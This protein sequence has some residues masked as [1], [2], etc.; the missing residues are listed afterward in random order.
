MRP[1]FKTFLILAFLLRGVMPLQAQGIDIQ[2]IHPLNWYVGMKNPNVQ[3][4]IYGKNIAESKLTLRPYAGVTLKS[5]HK[6]EN[7]NYL[8]VD[9]VIAKNAKAGNLQ[10][11]FNKKGEKTV[12]NYE[13]K[14]RSAKPQGLSP[15]DL[16]YLIMPDRFANGDPANDKF[17]TMA[18]TNCDRKAHSLRHGGDIQ[19]I[20]NHLDYINDLGATAIWLTPVIENDQPIYTYNNQPYSCYHGYAFTDHYQVDARFGD[21]ALYAKFVE[22]AHKKGLKIVQDAVY[23]HSSSAHWFFKDLPMKDWVHQWPTYTSSNYK[24]PTIQDPY[25]AAHD[26][27]L[28]VDGWFVPTMPDLNQNNPYLA[29]YLIQNAIWITEFFNIDAWRIDTYIYCDLAFMNRCNKALI[30]EFPG[31]FMFGEAWVHTVPNQAYFVKNNINTKF[32]SNQPSACDFQTHVAFKDA[33]VQPYTWDGSV[34]KLYNVLAQDFLYQK[35]EHLVTFLDNHDTDRFLS[36]VGDDVQKLKIGLTWLL[37]LRGIPQLYYGTEVLMKN[38]KQKSD[39]DIREDF[40]GGWADDPVN[41]FMAA[42]RTDA[43]ND[44]FNYLKKLAQYRRQSEALTQGKLTQF[45]PH[46]GIYVYSRH[47]NKERV[48]VISNVN[49]KE[50]ALKT[51]FYD[52]ILRG[53]KAAK[54]ILT[55][56]TITDLSTLK[57]PAKSCLVLSLK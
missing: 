18:D 44:L 24:N 27:K 48:V 51:E 47:T 7:P 8:F 55:D 56:E 38:T 20:I 39:G 26:K 50:I 6:V 14:N 21:N 35:P 16:I 53:A 15:K 11:V 31:I 23:N 28:M 42:G 17:A 25:A 33:L 46:D 37:T 5:I 19:G 36:A 29:N 49:E 12:R 43:E 9:L 10:L 30:D 52:E 41:K 22:E 34:N 3:L 13:L 32:K 45:T 57:I 2:K 1:Y 4:L 40:K 54:N